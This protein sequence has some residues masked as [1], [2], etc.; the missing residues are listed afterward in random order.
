MFPQCVCVALLCVW[1]GVCGYD[2]LAW[3]VEGSCLSEKVG[4]YRAQGREINRPWILW[5]QAG[6]TMPPWPSFKSL[7]PAWRL[8]QRRN[9]WKSR[10]KT[11]MYG[12][13]ELVPLRLLTLNVKISCSTFE[14][15]ALSDQKIVRLGCIVLQA[16]VTFPRNRG[17]FTLSSLFPYC[18]GWALKKAFQ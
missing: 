17:G 8:S 13:A 16:A 15:L 2:C 7:G 11:G 10:P 3:T 14:R 9:R 18:E 5:R 4:P 1:V 6:F 12:S